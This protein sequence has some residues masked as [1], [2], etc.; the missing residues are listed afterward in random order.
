MKEQQ[1]GNQW[2]RW[3]A[4]SIAFLLLTTVTPVIGRNEV[5]A[6]ELTQI[7]ACD[8]ISLLL[9]THPDVDALQQLSE[10]YGNQWLE[11]SELGL[12][13][14]EFAQILAWV[15]DRLEALKNTA[16]G[17]RV[18]PE[19]GQ[20][21]QRLQRDYR[22]ELAQVR[23]PQHTQ[24]G[25]TTAQES[26]FS[27]GG[28]THS[29]VGRVAPSAPFTPPSSI[30]QGNPR[31][32]AQQAP[33]AAPP[34]SPAADAPVFRDQDRI[35]VPG[36]FNTE[37]YTR[38][39]ENPFQRPLNAPLSTFSIDVDTASYSNVRRFIS[40]GQLPP[41]DAIRIEEL[42]NYFTYDYPQPEGDGRRP[43]YRH[44]PFSVT[45]EVAT[46]PWN[47]SHKLVQIGLKGQELETVQP[48]NL[49]FLVDV[50]GSM[51]SPNKLDLVKKSLCLL[52]NELDAQDRVS[53]VVYAGQ[54]GVVL[55]PTPGNQKAKIRQAISQL[56]AGGSTAGESGIQ[57]AYDLA[58]RYFRENGNN[59]V[60][61][62][63]DGDFNVG[64]SSDAELERLIEQKRDQGIFLTV[65]GYGTGNYKDNKME[66]LADK[67]NGNYAYIDTLLEAQKV[68]VQDLRSTLFT[69]AKDVKIQVEF[70]PAKVQAYRLIGYEN[71]LL[72]AEDFNDDQKD[73]GEIGAGHTVTALYEIIP[74]GVKPNVK[75]PDIDPLKYQ[76]AT[77][78][79]A[80]ATSHELMQVKL[81]YKTPRG[82]TSQLMSQTIGDGQS[83]VFAHRTQSV[84]A[85]NNLLF[86]A[87]VAMYGL[88]LRESEYRGS[89]NLAQVLDLAQQS[90]GPDHAGYRRAFIQLVQRTQRLSQSVPERES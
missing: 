25:D 18:R 34:P 46:A 50:S 7:K 47:P 57:L 80:A 89:A 3:S 72:Q 38:I 27:Q 73:A 40:Q 79:S 67:G 60:I 2:R 61:L 37:D 35:H 13:R 23:E 56:T 68:L 45:T 22:S 63:T 58:R 90:I 62:T 88:V 59:R 49:V 15:G 21:L 75:L 55:P 76:Q 32:L 86:A 54:A 87:A 16:E 29:K 84:S 66:L 51:H 30:E 71:R 78:P 74:T 19:D 6:Q 52:V 5:T 69:I 26:L 53:L 12:T 39:T 41:K 65:L 24:R 82:Q 11:G 83:P 8:D 10:R 36:T 28:S 48:S 70:N 85:S 64:V 44:H 81:R 77:N 14:W 9:P 20:T 31:R 42:V 1:W 43:P 4:G 17:S 33:G